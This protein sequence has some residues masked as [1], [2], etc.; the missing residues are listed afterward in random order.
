MLWPKGTFIDSLEYIKILQ[1]IIYNTTWIRNI[2]ISVLTVHR[3]DTLS[4]PNSI[5]LIV[6]R[7][8]CFFFFAFLSLRNIYI[9][10]VKCRL[11]FCRGSLVA[12]SCVSFKNCVFI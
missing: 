9:N 4:I 7:I 3:K 8:D 12:S 10:Y 11:S 1:L 6:S 2:N 5:D